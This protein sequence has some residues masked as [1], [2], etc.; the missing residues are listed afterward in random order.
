MKRKPRG[1][2]T[3]KQCKQ[4]ALKYSCRIDFKMSRRGAYN[5]AL[6]NGWLDNACNHM[7]RLKNSLGE[8][9]IRIFLTK[10][11][12][13]Y[14][15]Q[16]KFKD[17]ININP[18]PF[19]FYIQNYNSCIE[20]DGIHHFEPIEYFGGLERHLYTKNND[21]IKNQ[22][23]IDNSIRL[24]RIPYF[25]IDEINEILEKKIAFDLEYLKI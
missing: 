19:D 20:Y 10:A 2:W 8:E 17:C 13:L 7:D 16:K 21:N 23:C 9:R 22:Y 4:E 25:K 15:E 14:E 24:I 6:L 1:Y 5:S 18:L 12:I 11:Q 3:K